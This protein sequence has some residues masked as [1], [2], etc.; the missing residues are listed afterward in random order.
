MALIDALI[1]GLL[2]GTLFA[3]VGMGLTL[4]YGVLDIIN[5]AHTGFM[6]GGAYL[7]F[8]LVEQTGIHMY[9]T[10]PIV[11]VMMFAIGYAVQRTVIQ[12]VVGER[13]LF[14]FIL[15]F[16]IAEVFRGGILAT[17]GPNLRFLEPELPF[18]TVTLLGARISAPNVAMVIGVV[19]TGIL[20]WLFLQ[21]TRTGK[22]MRATRDDAFAAEVMGVDIPFI[23]AITMAISAATAG[24]AGVFLI[25]L[26]PITPEAIV[27]WLAYAFI[28]VVVGG[29]GSIPGAVLGGLTLGVFMRL[30][31]FYVGSGPG[32]ALAFF[33]LVALLVIRPTG[34]MGVEHELRH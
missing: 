29:L 14:V 34:I 20:T 5:L 8:V 22:A 23:Y 28:V 21:H 33:L 6:I 30:M 13:Q 2:L 24:V 16:G 18:D 12:R 15:T 1:G 4:V 3:L 31:Q 7:T 25:S 27:L 32:L 11:F 9:A 26:Q 19:I 17:I 10:I